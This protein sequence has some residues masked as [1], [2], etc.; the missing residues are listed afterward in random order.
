MGMS[1]ETRAHIFEPFFTTKRVGDGTGLGLS[2]VHG[3]VAQSGGFVE[4][5]SVLGN[6]ATFRLYLPEVDEAVVDAGLPVSAAK[7]VGKE[8]VLVVEDQSEVREYT[9]TALKE[10]G[11]SVIVAENATEALLLFSQNRERIDLV[12]T[13]VVMPSISGR[14]LAE[15]LTILQPGIKVLLMSGYM[16]DAIIRHGVLDAGIEFI[17]KPF[18]PG[19]LAIKIRQVLEP[20]KR[21]ASIL[22]VDDEA[23]VRSYL[24]SVLEQHGYEVVEAV[25][26]KRGFQEAIARRFDLVITDLVMPEQ[27]GIETIQALRKEMP[28]I[29]I[30]AISGNI[31]GP[32]LKIAAS[33]GAD[34]A[35]AK[36][37]RADLL[38]TTIAEVLRMRK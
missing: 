4:V 10:F 23:A 32:Y 30:I 16:D 38:L 11:Y 29:G 36:P 3:I 12:L 22:I 25:N 20:P 35:L 5:S 28:G 2:M 14:E 13:D 15:E 27:E 34:A 6:G 26:G 8:T 31:G 33:L 7:L 1:E 21:S 9:A 17:Q 19:Q 24:R 37:V 18:T